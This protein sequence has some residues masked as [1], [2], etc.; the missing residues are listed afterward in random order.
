MLVLLTLHTVGG[1]FLI[2][3]SYNKDNINFLQYQI[4]NP[5]KLV[6]CGVGFETLIKVNSRMLSLK[7]YWLKR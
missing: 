7:G 3:N 6:Y 2:G 5:T 4:K 1:T